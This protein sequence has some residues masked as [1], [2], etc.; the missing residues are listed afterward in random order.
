MSPPRLLVILTSL[1][2]GTLCAHSFGRPYQLPM[3]YWMYIYGAMAALLL[4]F[5]VLAWLLRAERSHQPPPAWSFSP[6]HCTRLFKP[7]LQGLMLAGFGLAIASGLLGSQDSYRN[8]NMTFFWI[9]FALGASYASALLGN[10]YA[11]LNPWRLLCQGVDTLHAGFCRGRF[12]YPQALAYWPALALYMGFIS[13]ELFADIRPLS[14]SVWLLIYSAIN[15]LATFLWGAR[16][17]FHYGE[18]FA[19]MFRLMA[20]MA[21][22]QRDNDNGQWQLRWPFSG[23]LNQRVEHPSLLIFLL[24]MLS[25]T[26]FDGLRETSLWFNLFWA[27]P[28]GVLSPL[29]GKHPLHAY[30]ELRPWYIAYEVLWLLMSP[31]I[32][33]GL[34]LLFLW[35]G[36]Q[37]VGSAL[38]LRELA[39]RFGYSLL[40]IALVYH[41]THYYSLLF[42]DGI[43]IRALLS[44]P[45]GWGWNLFGNAITG[46][47]PILLDMGIIW[48]SQVWL[49]L[50][51]HVASVYLAHREALRSFNNPR[52]AALSQ[53][54]MLLLMLL[55]TGAGLWILAQPLQA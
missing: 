16:A 1:L 12:S 15:L 34:F 9:V 5:V 23:L 3:P 28:F 22:L 25:S 39:L 29:L 43:K 26:A 27:D 24:F 20:M 53:L 11:A 55:F 7:L 21:P 35:L 46:R 40:P 10:W 30:I 37:L 2:P 17:W 52:R 13:L 38:S 44:D 51:G 14:L 8:F 54:P 4:S 48:D 41:I 47:V 42:S 33:L 32:Y 19:V 31:L 36:K 45:F 18:L 49:I 50:I 6:P